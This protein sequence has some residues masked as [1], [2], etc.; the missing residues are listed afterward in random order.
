MKKHSL[1]LTFC[2]AGAMMALAAAP[3]RVIA[4]RGYWKADGSAQNSI[5]SLVKADSI[6]AYASEFDVWIT[7]DD[8]LVVNH[9]A[10]YNGHDMETGVSDTI[11]AQHLKNGETL[12]TLDSYLEAAVPL[13]VDLVLELKAHKDTLREDVAID[14]IVEM[15]AAK[16]LTDRVTYISFSRHACEEFIKKGNGRPVYY[17][18]G[19]APEVVKEMGCTGP[20]FHYSHFMTKHPEWLAQFKEMNMPINVWT[21]DDPEVMQWVID[22]KIDYITTNLPEEAMELAAKAG[23]PCKNQC[24][25]K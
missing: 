3:T 6:G 25:K 7:A 18:T 9:D 13:K 2:M 5:R 20:D 24:E 16:G 23:C 4:H 21:V 10:T 14:K 22:N 8:V 1:I 17:L 12:P 19:K 15:V 11:L